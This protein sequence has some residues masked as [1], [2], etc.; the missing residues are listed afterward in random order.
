MNSSISVSKTTRRVLLAALFVVLIVELAIRFAIPFISGNAVHIKEIPQIARTLRESQ[1]VKIL[2]LGNSMVNNGIEADIIKSELER[3]G[4][5]AT[6]ITKINPD[7]TDLWDWHFLYKNYFLKNSI[8]PDII[9]VGFGRDLLDDQRPAN[10][11][12]LAGSFCRIQDLQDLIA[13]NLTDFS[14]IKEFL[15]ASVSPLYAN[16]ET[17]RNRLFDIFMPFFREISVRIRASE[18]EKGTR[19]YTGHGKTITYTR[20]EKF[21]DMAKANGS[22]VVLIAMPTRVKSQLGND[23]PHRLQRR[24]AHR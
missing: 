13:F 8:V 19:A 3:W 21:L 1:G 14:N 10:P 4:F 23:T 7:G 11:S 5:V 2:F 17:I 12:R 16:R 22:S 20:L 15:L 9:A 6:S 24:V 18:W